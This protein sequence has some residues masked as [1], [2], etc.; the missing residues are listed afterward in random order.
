MC[1]LLYSVSIICRVPNLIVSLWGAKIITDPASV[2]PGS[3][4]LQIQGTWEHPHAD[5][6]PGELPLYTQCL[7]LSSLPSTWCLPFTKILGVHF[8]TLVL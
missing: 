8:P 6:A 5:T 7:V 3:T 2:V 1:A 4:H